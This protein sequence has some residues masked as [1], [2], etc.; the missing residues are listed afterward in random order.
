M[1]VRRWR[2]HF[3]LLQH[4]AGRRSDENRKKHGHRGE[5]HT[6]HLNAVNAARESARHDQL[7][8]QLLHAV[9]RIRQDV[10]RCSGA[11]PSENRRELLKCA[12]RARLRLLPCPLNFYW[13]IHG[14]LSGTLEHSLVALL[15]LVLVEKSGGNRSGA[16]LR[17]DVFEQRGRPAVPTRSPFAQAAHSC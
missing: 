15:V 6:A 14:G 8:A 11:R 2:C 10:G 17:L 5:T 4:S 7:V 3:L 9:G 12:M 13:I 1:L 16:M